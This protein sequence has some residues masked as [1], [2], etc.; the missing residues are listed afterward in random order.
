[1]LDQYRS[2][3]ET[4]W[5]IVIQRRCFLPPYSRSGIHP[6]MH[7]LCHGFWHLFFPPTELPVC[8]HELHSWPLYNMTLLQ[9]KTKGGQRFCRRPTCHRRRTLSPSK[10]HA[11]EPITSLCRNTFLYHNKPWISSH[12]RPHLCRMFLHAIYIY[13]ACRFEYFFSKWESC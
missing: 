6:N 10:S 12:L 9:N 11:C 5:T 8:T 2:Q 7:I 4:L 1:M 13:I 3:G